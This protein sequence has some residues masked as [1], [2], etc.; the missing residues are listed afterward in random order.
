MAEGDPTVSRKV[1]FL[2]IEHFA[3]LKPHLPG[4]FQ[5]IENLPFD[6]GARYQLDVLTNSR[7]CAFPG[8]LGYPL[9]LRFGRVRRDLLPDVER[10]G[11]LK[12]LELQED[13]G[14]IDVC[15]LIIFEDGH[16]A[17]EFN[18]DGPRIEKLGMYLFEK[19]GNLPTA[20]KFLP[21]FERDIVEVV[22][23]LD[24]VR[25]LEFE[26]PPDSV[27]LLK[28]ADRDIATAVDAT[29]RAGASKKIGLTLSADPGTTALKTL[30]RRFAQFIASNSRNREAFDSLKAVGY[31][32]GSPV[33]RYVDILEQKLVSGELFPRNSTRSRS[34]QSD[35]AFDLI[36][37][38]YS[39]R[40]DKLPFAAVSSD[41]W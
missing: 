3:D 35:R 39:D 16:V 41:P 14:I 32:E 4:A 40:R 2:R 1:Y 19:G 30:A 27:T 18:H 38:A 15:H 9:K 34:I 21:L 10:G 5:R 31:A 8:T 6:D 11:N 12:A 28:E 17:A 22:A 25:L 29:R 20:P 13:E 26:V 7:L 23:K 24:H 37:K 33:S 36:E